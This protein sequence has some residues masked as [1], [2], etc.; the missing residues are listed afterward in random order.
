[1]KEKGK[2]ENQTIYMPLLMCLCTSLGV[3]VGIFTDNVPICLAIGVSLGMCIGS[4][5]D[6]LIRKNA[7]D[8]AEDE[9][10]W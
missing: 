10:A 7:K 2:P 8:T 9:E 3:V 4:L 5:V 1:M 6:A